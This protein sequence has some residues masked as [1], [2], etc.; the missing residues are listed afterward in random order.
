[1]KSRFGLCIGDK[2]LHIEK[3]WIGIVS[4]FHKRNSGVLVDLSDLKG[5][6]FRW[7]SQKYLKKL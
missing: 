1:M 5:V 2:V 6:R 7:V 3:K 4:D